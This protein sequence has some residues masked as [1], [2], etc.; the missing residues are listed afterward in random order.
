MMYGRYRRR[1]D[2]VVI[3]VNNV[4]YKCL[5]DTRNDVGI[6]EAD[7]VVRGDVEEIAF[8]NSIERNGKR[9]I[10]KKIGG[11]S[12]WNGIKIVIP[13]NVEMIMESCFG[14]CGRLSQVVFESDS[15]L[16][17]IQDSAFS[18]S[19]IISIRIPDTVEEIGPSVF[20]R[21]SSLCSVDFESN[22]KLRIMN[23]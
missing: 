20:R 12:E 13:S 16:R 14:E 19:G 9:Y 22:S 4:K 5:I 2:D 23:E 1:T 7:G 18:M 8:Q 21:C 10:V 6:A 15:E 11:F 3:G 17:T